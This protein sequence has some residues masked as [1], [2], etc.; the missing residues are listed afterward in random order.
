MQPAIMGMLLMR[1][2]EEFHDR[3]SWEASDKS[4]RVE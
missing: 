2:S 3:I 1:K 4:E